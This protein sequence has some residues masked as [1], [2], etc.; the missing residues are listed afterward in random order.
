MINMM[1]WELMKWYYRLRWIMLFSIMLFIVF[2]MLST[3]GAFNNP[4]TFGVYIL[5]IISILFT[6]LI[7]LLCVIIPSANMIIDYI[8]PH[9]Y[10]ER[11]VQYNSRTVIGVKLIVNVIIFYMG[12]IVEILVN[13]VFNKIIPNGKIYYLMRADKGADIILFLIFGLIIPSILLFF[14]MLTYCIKVDVKHRIILMIIFMAVA[15]GVVYLLSKVNVINKIYE[16]AGLII[17]LLAMTNLP[18]IIEDKY[19]PR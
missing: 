8:R 12:V 15:F 4:N 6:A 14:Y 11:A 10:M 18:S 2:I 17:V 13:L 19:E 1:K 3:L 5:N 7:L 9:R 16:W